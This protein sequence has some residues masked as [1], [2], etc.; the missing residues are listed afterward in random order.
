MRK[1]DK[2]ID[3]AIRVALTEA[4]EVAQ[5]ESEGFMWLTHFVNYNSFPGSLS[6][7]CVYDTNAHLAKANLDGMRSLI[8]KKLASINIDIKDIRRHVSFDT[9]EKCKIEN[10]GKWQERL[11]A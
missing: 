5:D 3:N 7:V 10:D 4:C 2:K 9:E 6:V 11:Q 1:T 8:K